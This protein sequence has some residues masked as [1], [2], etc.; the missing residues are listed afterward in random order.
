MP[1]PN[2]RK[3]MARFE[4]TLKEG[5]VPT[6]YKP[7]PGVVFEQLV[8]MVN[9]Y[10]LEVGVDIFIPL[11]GSEQEQ[12]FRQ[13]WRERRIYLRN[14]ILFNNTWRRVM[15]EMWELGYNDTPQENAKRK[16]RLSQFGTQENEDETN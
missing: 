13:R 9:S 7:I 6:L 14:N 3:R 15:R 2:N 4:R 5:G 8:A 10:G 12:R 16:I 11:T 1:T